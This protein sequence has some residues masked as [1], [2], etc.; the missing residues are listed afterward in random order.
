MNALQILQLVL[1]FAPTG[2]ALTQEILK[3][4][5]EIESVVAALPTEHQ[6]PVATVAAKALAAQP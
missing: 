1:Q 3:I 4:V 5:A 6:T 2:I